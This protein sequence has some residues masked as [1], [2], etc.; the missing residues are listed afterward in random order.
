[1]QFKL[2]VSND[3]F[4]VEDRC[5]TALDFYQPLFDLANQ[6]LGGD[7]PRLNLTTWSPINLEEVKKNRDEA[8]SPTLI[9]AGRGVK[10]LDR[11]IKEGW[12]IRTPFINN[13]RLKITGNVVHCRAMISV[14][15]DIIVGNRKI[16][17]ASVALFY[18]KAI[19]ET[20]N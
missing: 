18:E 3:E 4:H 10:L 5:Q 15:G 1:M 19:V 16:L 20:E 17:V 6:R 7:E 13:H 12:S 14:K 11:A 2:I 8:D 9:Y